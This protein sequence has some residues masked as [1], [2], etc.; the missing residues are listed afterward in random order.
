MLSSRRVLSVRSL[1][2]RKEWSI[3]YHHCFWVMVSLMLNTLH[4]TLEIHSG[5]SVLRTLYS[6]LISSPCAMRSRVLILRFALCAM[7][8]A[9]P[10]SAS[11]CD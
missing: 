11:I 2:L 3:D 9:V 6:S 7:R 4:L 10:Q 1:V 5:H 8:F